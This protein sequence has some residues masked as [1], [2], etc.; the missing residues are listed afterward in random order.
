M[1]WECGKNWKQVCCGEKTDR[2]RQL[3]THRRRWN[4]NIIM[5]LKEI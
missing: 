3:G 1:G 4:N 2:K 5:N